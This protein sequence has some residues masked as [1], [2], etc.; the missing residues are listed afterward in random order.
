MALGIN[1]NVGGLG[2]A[3]NAAKAQG[4]LNKALEKLSSGRALN[5]AS[6]G[7]ANLIISEMLRSQLGGISTTMRNAQ[8]AF[9]VAS[10]AEGGANEVNNL[11]SRARELAVRASNGTNTPEQTAAYQDELDNILGSIDRVADT[12]RFAGEELLDGSTPTRD[13]QLGPDGDAAAVE[14]LDF[15]DVRTSQ[16]GTAGGGD[17]LETLR[18]GGANDLA[19]DPG[20]ALQVID[21]AIS[22]VSA[23]RGEIGAFQQNTLQST[24]NNMAV[25]LENVTAMESNIGDLDIA[26]GIIEQMRSQNLL[27]ASLGALKN[28]SF[29]QQSVLQ[30]LG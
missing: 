24:M 18:A 25:A 28:S 19:N 6:D 21:Q 14:S 17:A 10:I 5:K 15:I 22:E 2:S 9:N 11:L 13:F 23:G 8:E 27:Q 16:L 30:L 3:N 7:P 1:A 29:Q 4:M 20:A 26:M 12:T